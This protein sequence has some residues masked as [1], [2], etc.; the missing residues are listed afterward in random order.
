VVRSPSSPVRLAS[1]VKRR[2]LSLFPADDGDFI[3]A[4]LTRLTGRSTFPN[5][6]LRGKSIGGS[7]DLAAMHEDGRLR[8]LFEKAGLQVRTEIRDEEA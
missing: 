1:E 6:I 5:V 8:Q 2:S 4:V 3:K 7:D